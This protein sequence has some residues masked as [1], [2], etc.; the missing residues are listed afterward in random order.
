MLDII[1]QGEQIKLLAEKAI[2]W[3]AQKT[4]IVADLHWGKSAHFRKHGIAIPGN[5]QTHDELRLAKLISTYDI[6]RLIV[7]GDLFHSRH[8]KEVDIFSHWRSLHHGLH[9][10]LV[11]GNH[12]ILPQE[13]Y[14][15][16]N[17]QLHSEGLQAG[18]FLV[19]HD[20]PGNCDTFCIH[21]HVHPALRIS[22]KGN[23][24]IKLS[25]FCEDA[26]R[27]IL[28]AFG[29][30]TGTHLLDASEHKHLY[31]IADETVMKWK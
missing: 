14:L 31:I 29:Q 10:D 21:G 18:P 5:T 2:Y 20:I 23:Q 13:K 16:W 7:A 28:P 8:N 3:P 22:G 26:H 17:L 15:S 24:S 9:I 19:M 11:T 27:F 4:L 30:F 12:D 25:C 1:L 6:E